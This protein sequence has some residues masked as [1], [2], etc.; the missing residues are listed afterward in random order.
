VL[1]LGWGNLLTTTR[2]QIKTYMV[3]CN[4]E[5]VYW[6]TLRCLSC[7]GSNTDICWQFVRNSCIVSRLN[8]MSWQT[9]LGY[10]R[11]S[12][13]LRRHV[14]LKPRAAVTVSAS[15]DR[16]FHLLSWGVAVVEHQ[17]YRGLSEYR[18]LVF[19]VWNYGNTGLWIN[20]GMFNLSRDGSLEAWLIVLTNIM[21]IWSIDCPQAHNSHFKC[22]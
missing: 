3:N 6:E 18:I 13:E 20:Y 9:G 2:N 16:V 8:L 15:S 1:H 10:W 19:N 22:D 5:R 11:L 14:L 21:G 12:M 17:N 4:C 7:C